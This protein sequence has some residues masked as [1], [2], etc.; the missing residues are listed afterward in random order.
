M[1]H[2]IDRRRI[3]GE[4]HALSTYVLY[5]DFMHSYTMF[6]QAM[7]PRRSNIFCK[8]HGKYWVPN[9]FE[10]GHSLGR[11]REIFHHDG[12]FPKAPNISH[13]YRY[14]EMVWVVSKWWEKHLPHLDLM[15]VGDA[16]R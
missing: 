3:V 10:L 14:G 1:H 11:I 16:L 6:L 12:C 4:E 13:T 15:R 5:F 2:S 8:P 9:F 7:T